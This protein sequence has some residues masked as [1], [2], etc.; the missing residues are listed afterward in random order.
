M[1]DAAFQRLLDAKAHQQLA[2]R[3]AASLAMV[4]IYTVFVLL[5]PFFDE[6]PQA[7]FGIGL[8][9]VLSIVIR[10]WMAKAYNVNDTTDTSAWLFKY[11]VAT[12][13]VAL[14]WALFVGTT[15][16]FYQTGWVFLLLVLSSAGIAAAATSSLAPNAH[17][18]RAY[19]LILIVP[20]VLMGFYGQTRPSVTLGVL[21]CIFVA[22]LILMIKD[23][24]HMFWSSLTTIEKL[25]L[26]KASLEKVVDEIAHNSQE[27]QE[28]STQLSGISGQ[29]SQGAEA[30]SA[31]SYRVAEA[32]VDFSA[33]SRQVAESMQH[34]TDKTSQVVSSIHGMTDT[35][36]GLSQ[37]SQNTKRIADDAVKQSTSATQKV[38][39]LG[40]SAQQVG[41]ITE[42]IK[43]ISEQTNLL[44]LNA[45]I[46]AARAGEAGKGFS[47]VANEIKALAMQ[48][49]DATLQIKQ[50]IDTIQNDIAATVG[51]IGR[52]SDITSQINQSIT[53]SAHAVE[54]Q[55]AT[56][57]A[58]AAAMTE[59]SQEISS[60]GRTIIQNS[61]AA[62][63]ISDDISRVS[64]AAGEVAANS[65]QVNSSASMLMGLANALNDIAATSRRG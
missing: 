40:S 9:L 52:I 25:N 57:K 45:T 54:E 18:A 55:S 37:A 38:S 28:A 15:F 43:E 16:V 41:K 58:I 27:L 21:L 50:Q 53:D 12:V 31:D 22:A 64:A 29:M 24:H 26:Q 49:A 59:A 8:L 36:N 51:E 48:T 30:M 23:N 44:A 11:S 42:A 65:T 39:Q 3:T 6:H 62:G 35:I 46:E 17:L 19:V 13:F 32:A 63:G 47:V 7:T 56:T 33:N 1:D 2:K 34:L 4:L 61:E 20:I 14:V 60:L 5:T 10:V